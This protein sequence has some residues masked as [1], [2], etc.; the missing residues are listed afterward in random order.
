MMVGR[1]LGHI[2]SWRAILSDAEVGH[3]VRPY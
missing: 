2:D 1:E 3:P